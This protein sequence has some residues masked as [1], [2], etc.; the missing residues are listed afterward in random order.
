MIYL[1]NPPFHFRPESEI[2]A[3]IF[4]LHAKSKIRAQII[5][6]SSIRCNCRIRKS[7]KISLKIRNLGK[8]IFKLHRSV[9]LSTPLY[10]TPY[11]L[12]GFQ[13]IQLFRAEGNLSRRKIHFCLDTEKNVPLVCLLH[14]LG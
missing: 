2:R 12:N 3:K 14:A 4:E 9:R 10:I 6:E 7:V 5:G 8:N 1:P 13:V 11:N